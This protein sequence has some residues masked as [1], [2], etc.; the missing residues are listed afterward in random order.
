MLKR[1]IKPT[2]SPSTNDKAILHLEES[3]LR[4]QENEQTH[5][6]QMAAKLRALNKQLQELRLPRRIRP[7]HDDIITTTSQSSA[8]VTMSDDPLSPKDERRCSSLISKVLKSYFGQKH[9][10]LSLEGNAKEG[11]C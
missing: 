6:T 2:H 4:A 3:I 9:E 11:T 7:H 8:D 1:Q 5:Q 10:R